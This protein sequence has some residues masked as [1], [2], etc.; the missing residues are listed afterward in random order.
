MSVVLSNQFCMLNVYIC[1]F[2]FLS[3]IQ[4]VY[5]LEEGPDT[6]A[7]AAEPIYSSLASMLAASPHQ[8]MTNSCDV[9]EKSG[10]VDLHPVFLDVE[11]RYGI[12]QASKIYPARRSMYIC[13]CV[14]SVVPGNFL[15]HQQANG[16][17]SAC[18]HST[19]WYHEELINTFQGQMSND[20]RLEF[21]ELQIPSN[22]DYYC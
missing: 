22:P 3:L 19:C 13:T 6:L 11:L 2:S 1:A 20:T 7:F 17:V 5:P 21:P 8:S 14:V 18:S 9:N 15:L 10:G 4:T 16:A 12:L